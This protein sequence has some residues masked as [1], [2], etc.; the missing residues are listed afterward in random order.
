MA[1]KKPP[2]IVIPKD[3]SSDPSQGTVTS[4]GLEL[5]DAERRHTV[6]GIALNSVLIPPIKQ[7][8][9]KQISSYYDYLV[10][11]Y[12]INSEN[13]ILT[14]NKINDRKMGLNIHDGS[15]LVKNV[16]NHNGLA[17]LFP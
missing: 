9:E 17:K 16:I 14:R 7:F 12:K 15:N 4:R 3:L 2:N 11:E 13:S 6:V 5:T 8:V 1:P 10:K